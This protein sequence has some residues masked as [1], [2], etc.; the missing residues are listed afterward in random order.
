MPG[1]RPG[2]P[3]AAGRRT[4]PR[5]DDASRRLAARCGEALLAIGALLA[6]AGAPAPWLRGW[7]SRPPWFSLATRHGPWSSSPEGGGEGLPYRSRWRSIPRGAG[8]GALR[9][10]AP[11][12]APAV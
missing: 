3:D 10:Q 5:P 8:L 11:T 9:N 2:V 4:A 6:L 7:S 12:Q 1:L